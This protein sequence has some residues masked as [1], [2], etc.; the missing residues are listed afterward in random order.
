[1]KCT[2]LYMYSPPVWRVVVTSIYSPFACRESGLRLLRGVERQRGRG[3]GDGRRRSAW[4]HGGQMEL[5]PPPPACL[6]RQE[7]N[8][9]IVILNYKN[10]LQICSSK[11]LMQFYLHT[12]PKK[13]RKLYYLLGFL[14]WFSSNETDPWVVT[15]R[16]DLY[17]LQ[18]RG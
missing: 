8:R 3:S 4:G 17:V 7:P 12:M 9:F 10:I 13:R 6:Q 16:T 2:L 5:L 18:I 15:F 1:M 11:I 14:K